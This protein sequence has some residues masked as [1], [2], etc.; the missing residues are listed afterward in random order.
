MSI[1]AISG[2]IG[3]GKDTIAKIIQYLTCQHGIDGDRTFEDCASKIDNNG[4]GYAD[5]YRYNSPWQIKKF[6]Y[7]LKQI[8]SLLTGIDVADLEKQ[9]VKNSYLGNE[10]MIAGDPPM[11][12]RELLQRLGTD[13]LRDV[14]HPNVHVN[15]LFADYKLIGDNL[16]EGE[17][18]KVREEDLIYSNWIIS[19]LRFPN[20]AQAVK[21]RG[22]LLIRVERFPKTI[23]RATPA[24]DVK[25]IPF[26]LGDKNHLDLWKGGCSKQHLSETALDLYDKW[27]YVIQNDSTI[28]DLVEKVKEI[29]KLEKI[30]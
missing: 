16:L 7:K 5:F 21:D 17:V 23:M 19:D 1:I 13:A 24:T 12:V 20:E 11:K 4:Y 18:R 30:I 25:E 27:D 14:I 6:A 26:D 28:E 3:F 8:V 29:L 15:A 9:E 22:G 2:K 10:W